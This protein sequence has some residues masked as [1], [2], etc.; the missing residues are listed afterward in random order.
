MPETHRVICAACQID[1]TSPDD[2]RPA[3]ICSCP[4]CGVSDSFAN[5][6]DEAKAYATELAARQLAD[7]MKRIASRNKGVTYTPGTIATRDYRFILRAL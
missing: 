5:V 1:L 6:L 3:D 7:H 2:P 4:Q